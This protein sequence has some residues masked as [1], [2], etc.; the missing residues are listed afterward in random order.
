MRQW[1]L[2]LKDFWVADLHRF[3]LEMLEFMSFFSNHLSCNTSLTAFIHCFL[4]RWKT[5]WWSE[6]AS[7][8][9]LRWWHS[10]SEMYSGAGVALAA[11]RRH[12][13]CMNGN[14]VCQV[15]FFFCFWWRWRPQGF[16]V[17]AFP[18]GDLIKWLS[19]SIV[20]WLLY[21]LVCA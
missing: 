16:T 17:D 4:L 15:S 14:F 18:S 7:G 6:R 9:C 1:N 2:G 19:D 13:F 8:S 21:V 10:A 11:A 12:D 5:C 3:E 20:F